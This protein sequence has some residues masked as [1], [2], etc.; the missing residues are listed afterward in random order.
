MVG[1]A[2]L[3][4]PI[5]LSAVIVFIASAV[6]HMAL[7]YHWSD[8]SALPGEDNVMEAMRKEG[9]GPGNYHMPHA[10]SMAQLRSPEVVE[11][12]TK[13]PVGFVTIIPSGPPAM[14]KQLVQWFVFVLVIGVVVA[15][16]T[17][18]TLGPGADYLQ[19]FRVAGTVAFLGFVGAEPVNSIWKGQKWSTS[20]KN[21][22]DGLVY[23]LL[24]GG[25]FGW[26]WP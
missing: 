7:K 14:G 12:F 11:K 13:G 9:V 4:L 2:A 24:T 21:L 5:L 8:Y 22:F 19:V 18:R 15:Y 10:G 23:A 17:G 3:W 25:V 20:L 26:L 6:I 16:L 1:F